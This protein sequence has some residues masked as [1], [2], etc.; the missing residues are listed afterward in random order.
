MLQ[1]DTI[2]TINNSI[3][4]LPDSL[5]RLDSLAKADSLSVV[6][7][8]KAV[9][10]IPHGFVGIPHPSFPQNESWV[11]ISSVHFVFSAFV[12]SLSQSSGFISETIKTFFQ[13]KERSSIFSKRNC[14]RFSI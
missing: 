6:D 4:A 1:P 14:K 11:F 2:H 8:L 3:K 7:S 9:A 13:V 5:A 12:Y 10:L